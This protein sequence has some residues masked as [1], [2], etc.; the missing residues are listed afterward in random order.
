MNLEDVNK[1]CLCENPLEECL[2]LNCK[3]C[4]KKDGLTLESISINEEDE[5]E[6][7]IWE[8]NA[9]LNEIRKWAAKYIPYW[10]IQ[11]A[12]RLAICFEKCHIK[13]QTAV[14]HFD[15]A[16]NWNVLPQAVQSF[17]W[18]NQMISIFIRVATTQQETYSF[19][20]ISDKI[21]QDTAHMLK[22][23]TIH[24]QL[25]LN[26]P[27]KFHSDL[28]SSPEVESLASVPLKEKKT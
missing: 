14:L 7:A 17:H 28:L 21:I 18:K 16:E 24:L 15:F 2:L 3:L 20:A 8:G 6:L 12:Q 1:L 5:A 9:F 13:P 26:L 19:G 10:N 25:A 22:V 4:P 11:Q 27:N 23:C